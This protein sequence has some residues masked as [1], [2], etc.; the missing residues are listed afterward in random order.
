MCDTGKTPYLILERRGGQEGHVISSLIRVGFTRSVWLYLR[1]H[2]V[3]VFNV[4]YNNSV[5]ISETRNWWEK[6]LRGKN[7]MSITFF[8]W[9]KEVEENITSATTEAPLTLLC[10]T[11]KFKY[12]CKADQKQEIHEFVSDFMR[13]RALTHWEVLPETWDANSPPLHPRACSV[14]P[15]SVLAGWEPS[16]HTHLCC[17]M[18]WLHQ[19]SWLTGSPYK[20]TY[21]QSQPNALMIRGSGTGKIH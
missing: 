20:R 16:W 6:N 9:I 7:V 17:L 15:I 3:P 2:V 10:K 1:H 13:Q 19:V 11:L 21:R 8:I 5:K 14:G 4:M 12:E 18:L